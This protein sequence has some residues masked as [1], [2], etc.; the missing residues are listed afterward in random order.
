M[1]SLATDEKPWIEGLSCAKKKL[2]VGQFIVYILV[3]LL[4]Y[5]WL[6]SEM[7]EMNN[8]QSVTETSST[9]PLYIGGP[10]EKYRQG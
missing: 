8:P 4:Y 9:F 6:V 10:W 3:L 1:S 7:T 5:V 2:A